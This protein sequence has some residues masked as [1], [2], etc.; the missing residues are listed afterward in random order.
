MYK[1]QAQAEA[2]SAEYAADQNNLEVTKRLAA[3]YE[4]LEQFETALSFY[5]W[6]FHLSSNDP[7]LEKKVAATRETVNKNH[8]ASLQQF[9]DENPGHPDIEQ[10]R[11]QLVEAEKLQIDTLIAE[12]RERVDRNPTDNE[13]RYELG[14]RLFRATNFREAIQ[15]LQQAK[16]SPNLRIRVMNILGQCYDQMGTVSYTHLTLPTRDLV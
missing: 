16:R 13:L 1:R 4:E 7:A 6:A 3:T 5:E 11:E 2:L 15:H 8:L 9:V 12:S 14:S 10:Y